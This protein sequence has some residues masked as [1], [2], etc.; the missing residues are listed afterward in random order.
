MPNVILDD[1]AFGLSMSMMKPYPRCQS[2]H[3][4][5]KA[6]YNY[7][8]SRARRTTENSFGVLCAYFRLFFQPIAVEP[9]EVDKIGT[10]SCIL[11]NLLRD[12][13]I[14]AS[15]ET[16]FGASLDNEPNQ[17]MP[18]IQ[19]ARGRPALEAIMVRDKFKNYFNGEG[20]VGWQDAMIT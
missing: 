20:T 7:R 11:Y 8:H 16:S 1:E 12:A 9:E 5:T 6:I 2:L 19:A 15:I 4:R 18:T 17:N 13:R 10:A 14:P 3:D